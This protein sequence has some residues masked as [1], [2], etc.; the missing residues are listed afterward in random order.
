MMV[1]AHLQTDE[2]ALEGGT[3]VKPVSLVYDERGYGY[4]LSLTRDLQPLLLREGI[5]G[6]FIAFP[7]YEDQECSVTT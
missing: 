2:I 7:Y 6:S 1:Y 5:L 3:C 4:L